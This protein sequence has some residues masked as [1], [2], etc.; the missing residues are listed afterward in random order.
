MA[1]NFVPPTPT[2]M[3]GTPENCWGKGHFKKLF[4]NNPDA[5]SNSADVVTT[6]WIREQFYA[7]LHDTLKHSKTA[8]KTEWNGHICLGDFFGGF[9][10][11]WG[12]V[13]ASEVHFV[14]EDSWQRLR[15]PYNIVFPTTCAYREAHYT[16]E[17]S[18]ATA[19]SFFIGGDN[20]QLEID[21]P[22]NEQ[23]TQV[24]IEWFAIGF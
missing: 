21:V 20:K 9:I 16:W 4:V 23:A 14:K 11:Q 24:G 13:R 3:L 10:L 2:S 1:G 6:Q 7:L 17:N 12:H 19:R 5:A 22:L 18:Q 8:Y 15:I